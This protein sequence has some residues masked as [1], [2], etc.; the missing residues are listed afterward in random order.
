MGDPTDLASSLMSMNL[1]YDVLIIGAGLSGLYSLISM[2]RLG[3]RARVIERGSNVGGVWYWNRYPGA[4]FDSE[5]YTYA[6]TFSKELLDEW[7]WKEHFSAQPDTLRYI[8]YIADK[9]D[10]RPQVEF[11]AEVKSAQYR[12]DSHSW[13]LT[14]Q[15][16]HTYTSRFLINALGPLTTPTLPNIPGVHDYKGLAYHTSRW[17]H[18]PVSFENKRVGVIGTGATGIQTIQEVGKTAKSLHVFQRTANWT[19][20]MRN[21]DITP[22]EMK[23]LRASY[24]EIYNKCKKSPMGF[25]F[26]PDPRNTFDVP[27]EE[28]QAFWEELYQTRGL[29]KWVGNFKDLYMN[30]EANDE[31]SKWMAYKVR[32]R[33][34]DPVVAEKLIPKD[35]GFGLR[36][37]PLENRYYELFNRENV[38]LV[39]L[40]ETPITKITEHGIKTTS[41]EIELDMIIYATGFDALTGSYEEIDY[42]G[43][44]GATLKDKWEKGPRTYL[45]LTVRGFPNMF[46][47]MGPHQA[48][49]NI[50][51]S[52]EYAVQWVSRFMQYMLDNNITYINADKEGEEEWTE[53]VFGLTEGLLSVKID[54]WMTGVNSNRAGKQQR[55]IIRYYGSNL[56]FRRRCEEAAANGYKHFIQA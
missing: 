39:D 12:E 28:R 2:R 20:P 55:R 18:E 4:R 13:L 56:E 32:Q 6:F 47:I 24:P 45:G 40:R 25:M 31:F 7:N 26:Q 5:S 14:D 3:L 35:H 37:V 42:R 41:E 49:G 43:E 1:D 44:D 50:P 48:L 54:S 15:R 33:V 34:H 11:H 46:N 21:N 9:F 10:L 19:A 51:H 38:K 36:R 17:P 22:E 23:I 27:Q 52:I 16:G 29:A 8:N 53:H 30:Q